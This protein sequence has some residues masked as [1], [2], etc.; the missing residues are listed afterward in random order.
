MIHKSGWCNG[1]TLAQKPRY[2]DSSPNPSRNFSLEI[3]I[4]EP[5]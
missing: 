5:I 2:T 4:V 1:S 3:I